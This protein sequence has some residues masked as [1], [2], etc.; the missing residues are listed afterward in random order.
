MPPKPSGKKRKIKTLDELLEEGLLMRGDDP[1]LIVQRIPVGIPH[2]DEITNGGIP[3]HRITIITG[4]YS[5]G[6]SFLTQIFMKNAIE[7]GLQVAY[8]DTEQTYDPVWWDAVGL[9]LHEILVS[10][11]TIGEEAVNLS[12]SLVEAGTDIVVIDSLAALVPHEETEEEA[13]KKFIGLQ[14]R[15]ISKLMRL[16]LS[17]KHN[18][19]VVCTNQLRDSI[20]GP[21]PIDIMPGGQAL[22]FHT[23]IILRMYRTGWIEEKG[24][25]KG[26]TMKV[27]CSKS[28][29]GEPWKECELPFLFRGK[30]DELSMLMD[31]GIEAG[32]IVQKGPYYQISFGEHDGEKVMGRNSFLEQLEE[33][34]Q[35]QEHL[36]AALGGR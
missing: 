17:T 14:A 12:V 22:G 3:R 21:F 34:E 35:M 28:K 11:P 4:A 2:L 1:R 15:L 20:G 24:V 19:A 18:S 31:S 16:L 27:V 6:K 5:S 32:L 33:D 26:F 7:Q 23:S 30:I 13:G 8:I 9:P 36:S 10:Q 29:V 25:R